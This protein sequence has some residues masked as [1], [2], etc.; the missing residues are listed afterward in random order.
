ML[1]ERIVAL[2]RKT[3]S[4]QLKDRERPLELSAASWKRK[5]HGHGHLPLHLIELYER[6]VG[7]R[8]QVIWSNLHRAHGSFGSE[9]SAGL[10]ADLTQAFRADFDAMM[11]QQL[12]PRFDVDL[13]DFRS[14][15]K[16]PDWT[17]QLNA[18]RDRELARYEAEI[19]HY[20]A[21]LEA[22]AARGAPAAASY[23]IHGNVGAVVTGAGAVTNV[24][25]NINPDQ[26]EALLKA[27]ELVKHAIGAAPELEEQDRRELVEFAD[28][29]A[30]E[31][32]KE[33]PNTRRLSLTLQSLAAAVQGIASAP[34]AYEV[35]SSAAVA[36]GI[37]V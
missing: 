29:A 23:V 15:A 11:E 7:A 6:E 36:I 13:K 37:P 8:A 18:A 4:I 9:L 34:G 28:E 21:L 14:S 3:A 22:A 1:D 26:R 20:V 25:Q 10:R 24:V 19:E 17:A 5:L 27:L 31:V 16:G 2:S 30:G 12:R 35:L 33:R 32:A